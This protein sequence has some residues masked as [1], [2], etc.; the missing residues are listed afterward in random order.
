MEPMCKTIL[1]QHL[2]ESLYFSHRGE[3]TMAYRRTG[4][5]AKGILEMGLRRHYTYV[6]KS[7]S[8][9]GNLERGRAIKL[10]WCLYCMDCRWSH[11]TGLPFAVQDADMDVELPRK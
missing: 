10:F 4:F 7:G 5:A 8:F 9:P 2:A 1:T 3:E 11:G 6:R